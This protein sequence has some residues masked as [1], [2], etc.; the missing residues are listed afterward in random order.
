MLRPNSI[1]VGRSD[2]SGC[3]CSCSFL[4]SVHLPSLRS[5]KEKGN[6][7]RL[8]LR[9]SSDV[10]ILNGL[11]KISIHHSLFGMSISWSKDSEHPLNSDL[12]KIMLFLTK[13][14]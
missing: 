5:Q 8:P 11:E 6:E 1:K 13:L 10:K 4:V 12:I 7:S 2:Q 3:S 9:E 14:N